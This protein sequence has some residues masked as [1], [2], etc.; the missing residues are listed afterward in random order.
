M[1]LVRRALLALVAPLVDVQRGERRAQP[2]QLLLQPRAARAARAAR[3]TVA[4]AAAA[5]VPGHALRA[6]RRRQRREGL[7]GAPVER[8]G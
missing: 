7:A 4:A 5:R 2:A 6:A 1:P 3:A 8:L